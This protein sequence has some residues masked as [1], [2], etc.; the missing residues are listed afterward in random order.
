MPDKSGS[1]IKSSQARGSSV[2]YSVVDGFAPQNG[3][4]KSIKRD[5]AGKN[6]AH[7]E[8][9]TS[10]EQAGPKTNNL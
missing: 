1:N 10:Q 8:K 6:T 4:S 7:V 3:G 9:S 2:D 5:P